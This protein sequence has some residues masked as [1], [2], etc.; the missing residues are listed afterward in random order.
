MTEFRENL[1]TRMIHIY[2]FEHEVT[3]QYANV[4]E[5]APQTEESDRKLEVIVMYHEQYPLNE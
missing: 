4:L 2:G 3:I 1:L 5:N